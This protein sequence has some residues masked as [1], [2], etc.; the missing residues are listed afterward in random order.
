MWRSPFHMLNF[1]YPFD[2]FAAIH[3][4]HLS[5][6]EMLTLFQNDFIGVT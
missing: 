4:Q 5:S 6:D 3:S 2:C 1:P